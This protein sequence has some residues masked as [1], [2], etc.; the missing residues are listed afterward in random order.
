MKLNG[1][2]SMKLISKLLDDNVV[3]QEMEVEPDIEFL[4]AWVSK[5]VPIL[6]IPL[7][8]VRNAFK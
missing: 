6:S 2:D 1:V 5:I 7:P 8:Y 3:R 4:S